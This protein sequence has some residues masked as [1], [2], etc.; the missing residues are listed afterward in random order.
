MVIASLSINDLESSIT[1][2]IRG[3]AAMIYWNHAANTF[4][5]L[6]GS[7]RELYKQE[8]KN[9]KNEIKQGNILSVNKGDM[10][11]IRGVK[12]YPLE[13]EIKDMPCHAYMLVAKRGLSDDCLVTPYFFKS[14][15]KR[16]QL[17]QYM[18]GD[19]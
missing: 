14:E 17:Y 6:I 10:V 18:C 5:Y 13:F 7:D 16:N 8:M 2:C 11:E 19:N 15:E 3:G 12:L 9:L 1:L 4:D